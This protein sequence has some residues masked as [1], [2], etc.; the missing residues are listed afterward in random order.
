MYMH[1]L[2]FKLQIPKRRISSVK[3]TRTGI[4]HVVLVEA[5]GLV[6]MDSTN[7]S[8]PYCKIA[9]GKE[10]QRTKSSQQRYLAKG[11]AG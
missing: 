5:R 2:I 3:P 7:L 6:A 11:I 9:L 8:D 10:R 4:V 1:I